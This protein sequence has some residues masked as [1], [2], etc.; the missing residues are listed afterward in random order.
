MQGKTQQTQRAGA[1]VAGARV[2]LCNCA[3]PAREGEFNAWYDA[4]AVDILWPRLLVNVRRYRCIEPEAG[5]TNPRYFA[6]Y[7]ILTP[8]L[9]TAWPLTRDHPTRPRRERSPLLDTRLAATFGRQAQRGVIGS[10][11][12]DVIALFIDP[13]P[14]GHAVRA[15]DILMEELLDAGTC[16]GAWRSE[17]V[18]ED[19]TQ[20]Q[21]MLVIELAAPGANDGA[22]PGASDARRIL[23]L[24]KA[25]LQP[26]QQQSRCTVRYLA[27][28]RP[29][30]SS[31]Y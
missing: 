14:G 26:L 1:T 4:Y 17:N 16:H 27:A 5:D 22:G 18:E 10:D 3:D 21:V 2:V 30:F 12:T 11:R 15:L 29:T 31:G 13:S 19:R 6:L 28:Y 20:P 23:G 7:D 8:E 24:I 25:R 9:A